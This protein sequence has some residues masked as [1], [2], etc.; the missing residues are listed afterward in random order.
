MQNCGITLIDV[1]IRFC[2]YT[3]FRIKFPYKNVF[4]MLDLNDI[5]KDGGPGFEQ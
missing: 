2:L 4:E 5:N 3:S 1:D